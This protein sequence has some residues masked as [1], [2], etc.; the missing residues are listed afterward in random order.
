M[1]NRRDHTKSETEEDLEAFA[2][3]NTRTGIVVF[4]MRDDHLRKCCE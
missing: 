3:N 2:M 1:N 4:F